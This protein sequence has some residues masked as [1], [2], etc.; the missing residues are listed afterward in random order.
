GRAP[1][2]GPQGAC[3]VPHRDGGRPRP[4]ARAGGGLLTLRSGEYAVGE[5]AVVVLG[6]A[7]V[8][9]LHRSDGRVARVPGGSGANTAL[10]LARLG[11]ATTLSTCLGADDDGRL[12]TDRLRGSGVDLVVEPVARTSTARALLGEGGAA[13]YTFDVEWDPAPE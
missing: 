12:I 7:L 6:E 11:M 1:A 13:D 2:G 4:V 10:A 8:D 3:R 5:P 9:V